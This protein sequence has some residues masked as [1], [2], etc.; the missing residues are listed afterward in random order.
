MIEGVNKALRKMQRR[1]L[2]LEL[3]ELRKEG[4]HW[5]ASKD[6]RDPDRANKMEFHQERI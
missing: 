3:S 4:A 1:L 6:A 5:R 2:I